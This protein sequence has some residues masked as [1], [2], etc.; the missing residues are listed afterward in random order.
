MA[1]AGRAEQN[2]SQEPRT[3]SGSSTQWQRPKQF[4]LIPLLFQACLQEAELDAQ[5]LKATL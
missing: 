2:E 5:Q 3:L 1:T 4:D